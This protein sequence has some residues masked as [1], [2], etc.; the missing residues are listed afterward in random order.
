[1]PEA[2]IN[3]YGQPIRREQDVRPSPW[4]AG[5]RSIDEVTQPECVQR[6]P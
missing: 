6:A 4:G 5:Q 1:M 3:E 2:P